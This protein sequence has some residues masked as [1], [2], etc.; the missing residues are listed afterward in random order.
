MGY[1]HY[2]RIENEIDTHHFEKIQ[3]QA[4]IFCMESK[5]AV[6]LEIVSIGDKSALTPSIKI[7]G[8]NKGYIGDGHETF[9]LEP[10]AVSFDCCK[11][12]EKAYDEIVVAVL[13]YASHFG[14]EWWSDGGSWK[15]FNGRVLYACSGLPPAYNCSERPTDTVSKAKTNWINSSM[16]EA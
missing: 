1:T 7:E 11:T 8:I 6:N 4:A 15:H 3:K 12:G 2:W 9:Y 13:I 16:E 10:K 14:V 5:A